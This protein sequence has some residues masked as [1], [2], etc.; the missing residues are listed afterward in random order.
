MSQELD[1]MR[2]RREK[3]EELKQAG[4]EP[5]GRRFKRDHLAQQ[6]RDEYG[7]FDKEELNDKG[8]MV[9][10]AGRMTRKRSSGKAG[11]ADFVD[12]TGKIQV[13]AR[14]DMVGDE[15]YH[16]FKRADIGDFLGIEGDV[17]KTNTGELT[18]RAHKITF[19]SKALRPLPN[20]WEGVTDPETIYRQRYLDL[21]SNP[22]SFKRFH[23]RTAIIKAVR[24]YMDDHGFT[25]VETPILNTQAGGAN[26]RPFVTHHNALDIDMYLR[27]ATELYLK[28]LIVGGFERV[29]ELG[30]IFRNEGMDPHHNPEFTTME[31]YAAY[32][33][34]HDVMD[35]TEGIVK[36]A[37]KVVSDDGHVTY[38]G[39]DIDLASDFKRVTMV[40]AVKEKTGIDFGDPAMTDDDAKKL[41]DEHHIEYKSFWK[42]GHILSA[43]FDEYVEKTL[44]QPT[45]VYEF[46]VEVSPLAKRNAD[47]PDMTDR[48][49]LYVDGSELA[50]AF[51]ELND[52]IDQKHRFEMQAEE[53]ANG[54]DEAE[55]VDLDYVQALEYG[56]PP[57]GGLGIGIDR[58][59]ML[60]TDAKSIRDVI[61]FPTMRPEKEQK[62]GSKKKKNNKK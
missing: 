23:Q 48:F 60:L 16:I 1:Q 62:N 56:M 22:E 42:K 5:F 54:N 43:F 24:K 33:D 34:F 17:I 61:L 36:A 31:T 53:K 18:V 49:E 26:A 52:P 14:K 15:Q 25:E 51:S 3:M 8:A 38:Q 29:Y 35:E 37:A 2:V 41:A 32:F 27:I 6:I 55:P 12:R 46:P 7:Q 59:V 40:D 50:N 47:N 30:R 28:R 20:K 13:Y 10:I 45:F 57:T 4:I 19:L 58:L 9:I 39:H 44:I 21:I 11:F